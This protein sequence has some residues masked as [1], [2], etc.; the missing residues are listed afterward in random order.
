MTFLRDRAA[1][2]S[3]A[4]ETSDTHQPAREGM[5]LLDVAAEAGDLDPDDPMLDRL[6]ASGRFAEVAGRTLFMGG[7]D[8]VYA[9]LQEAAAGHLSDGRQALNRILFAALEER[10]PE[11]DG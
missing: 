2:K 4:S 7:G 5:S 9:A 11:S 8:A 3:L 1:V 6:A 10:P